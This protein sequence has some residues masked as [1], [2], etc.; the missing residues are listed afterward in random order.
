MAKDTTPTDERRRIYA[1]LLRAGEATLD[2]HLVMIR[3]A[4]SE[5]QL[6]EARR[7]VDAVV[8]LEL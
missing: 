1:R 4:L 7:L 2:S 5:G 8:L 3:L 6:D